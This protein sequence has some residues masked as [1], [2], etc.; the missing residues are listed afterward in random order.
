ME[1]LSKI[2]IN[3]AWLIS[4]IINFTLLLVILRAVLYR[5]I[6]NMLEERKKRIQESLEEAER[7]K[8]EATAQEADFQKRLE[9][10]RRRAREAMAQASQAA[11]RAK[12]EILAQA[13]EEAQRILE[14]ARGQIE[15][16]RRQALSQIKDQVAELSILAA[17]QVL[18]RSLDGKVHREI[19]AE[20][21]DQ[22]EDLDIEKKE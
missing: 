10:E 1:V 16:E 6:L 8:K 9:E 18:G 21:L 13:R 22:F 7:V 14:Q 20:F 2:G 12:E 17:R 11:E 19:I 4:Q 15:Y 3:E 5:P